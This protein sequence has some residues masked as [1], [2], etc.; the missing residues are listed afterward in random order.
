MTG[1]LKLNPKNMQADPL[2]GR[3]HGDVGVDHRLYN[4][5]LLSSIIIILIKNMGNCTTSDADDLRRV[6]KR[7]P[8]PEARG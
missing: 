8:N 7:G 5:D 4:I 6:K 3:P 2:P 1:L